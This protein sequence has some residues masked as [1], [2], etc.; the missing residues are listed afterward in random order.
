EAQVR[1]L[2]E[3][4]DTWH[5]CWL[6]AIVPL[7]LSAEVS[8]DEASQVV[9]VAAELQSKIRELRD[10]RARIE[11]FKQ[12]TARFSQEVQSLCQRA[13][14]DLKADGSPGSLSV[15]AAAQELLRRFRNA[16]ETWNSR[17]A[18]IQRHEAQLACLKEAK[19]TYEEAESQLTALCHEAQ[20]TLVDELPV[21]EQ[22]SAQA[23]RLH[24]RLKLLDDQI[25]RLCNNEPA[26]VFQQAALA[27]D[28]DILPDQLASLTAEINRFEGERDKLNQTLGQELQI[29]RQ[30][31]G[32]ARAAEAAEQAEE[33]K[34]RLAFDVEEYARLRLA[35][36]VLEEA[37]ERY[38]QRS[39]GAVLS[40]AA[41][42]FAR[43][44]LGSFRDLKVAY[45]DHDQPVL[46]AV[47]AGGTE[48]IGIDG[49]SEGSADQL[50]L[51]L[52]L[53]SLETY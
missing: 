43:L 29:L 1:N 51:A 22:R 10:A 5:E 14:P 20:C 24:D 21:L 19:R 31:D 46:Q 39:Q 8:I 13:A 33:L 50:Y 6:A 16:Q 7:G 23:R 49:L 12:E 37:I 34:A 35:A 11:A 26:E 45:D 25:Q 42:L 2:A 28:L 32:S 53:A 38:R 41:E 52:R 18:L 36:V 44:T 3:R 15:E 30:M 27:I 9:G 48:T 40:R 47:R 17:Q 4:I